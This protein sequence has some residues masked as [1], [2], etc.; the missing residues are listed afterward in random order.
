M[1]PNVVTQNSKTEQYTVG[2]GNDQASQRAAS[3][4]Q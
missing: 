2:F 4:A 1:P 3:L